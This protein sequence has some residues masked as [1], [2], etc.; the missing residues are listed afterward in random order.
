MSLKLSKMCTAP[1]PLPSPSRCCVWHKILS[2]IV[3]MRSCP[4]KV[5]APCQSA[6]L[7]NC[8]GGTESDSAI[9]VH[10]SRAYEIE[11]RDNYD[12]GGRE[13]RTR[14][15]VKIKNNSQGFIRGPN[16]C[17]LEGSLIPLL[18]PST[19]HFLGKAHSHSGDN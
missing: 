8:R 2:C 11:E 3:E 16:Q 4:A 9:C 1:P 15:S 5:R 13:G 7:R 14:E 17:S 10:C 18:N 19:G 6:L 12:E